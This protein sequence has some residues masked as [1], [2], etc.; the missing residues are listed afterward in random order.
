MVEILSNHIINPVRFSIGIE[1]MINKGFDTFIE[2]G[3]GKTL[4]GFVKRINTDK[5]IN[6]LNICDIG[7][8]EKTLEFL[9]INN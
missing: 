8:Y 1:N 9:K 5:K 3:P 6:I 7:S 4:S 2:I